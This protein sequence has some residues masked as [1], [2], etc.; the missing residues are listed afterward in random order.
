V[1]PV[2]LSP[3]FSLRLENVAASA[4]LPLL[5][6]RFRLRKGKFALQLPKA[7]EFAREKSPKYA[8][9]FE[10]TQSNG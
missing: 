8:R 6:D 3:P 10:S 9:R 4:F 2:D 5:A 7:A 1:S